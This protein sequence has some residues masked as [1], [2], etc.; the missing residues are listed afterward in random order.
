MCPYCGGS[1][2]KSNQSVVC[3]TCSSHY[4]YTESGNLD[5]RLHRQKTFHYKFELGTPFKRQTGVNFGVLPLNAAPEVDYSKFDPPRNISRELLSHFPKAK[6]NDSLML[7]L[8]CGPSRSLKVAEHAGFEYVGLDNSNET[9]LILG[10]AHSLPFKDESF[11]FIL[12]YAVL[13]HIRFPFVMMKEAYRVLKTNGTFIG[14]VSFLEP[15]HAD[16]FYHHTHLGTY[17][18][19]QEGGFYIKYICYNPKWS[20]LMAQ[21]IYGLFPKMPIMFSKLI[22]MPIQI[23]HKLWWRI[24]GFVCEKAT[25][26]TRIINTSGSYIFI[27]RK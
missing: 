26:E 17:N 23:I 6:S 18:S 8:G 4:E 2:Q 9:A 19:L 21:A 25:E 7:D 5:L 24:G 22:V 11:E 12:S 20:V 14:S 13:E 1:L 3:S 27:A 10:D 15:F 16:S